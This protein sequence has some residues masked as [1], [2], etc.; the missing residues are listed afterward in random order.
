MNRQDLG[1][2]RSHI[3]RRL[4]NGN[5]LARNDARIGDAIGW[6][7]DDRMSSESQKPIKYPWR[8]ANTRSHKTSA[9]KSDIVWFDQD[10]RRFFE[11]SCCSPHWS[12][13]PDEKPRIDGFTAM[14]RFRKSRE[15]L[16]PAL[17]LVLTLT[18]CGDCAQNCVLEWT[19]EVTSN[20]CFANHVFSL[21]LV[22]YSADCRSI[23]YSWIPGKVHL[24]YQNLPRK[25]RLK[26]IHYRTDEKGM[27][28]RLKTTVSFRMTQD[29]SSIPSPTQQI[30]SLPYRFLCEGFQRKSLK[31]FYFHSKSALICTWNKWIWMS[32]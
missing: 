6:L 29:K 19:N 12:R 31:Q 2:G 7:S 17:H 10:R 9:I 21:E 4:T 27:R 25:H 15:S 5:G 11:V 24:M 22:G 14:D 28:E 30:I 16:Y 1:V 3:C 26:V 13:I 20:Y 32:Y 8:N 23:T 18:R